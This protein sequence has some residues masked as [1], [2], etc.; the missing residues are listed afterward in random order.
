MEGMVSEVYT[1][2]FF[3]Y[4]QT[5]LW[6]RKVIN[7]EIWKNRSVPIEQNRTILIEVKILSHQEGDISN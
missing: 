4:F 2:A 1:I 6:K 5:F 3:T 7:L